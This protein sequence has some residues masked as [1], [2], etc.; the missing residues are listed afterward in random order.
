MCA[1]ASIDDDM[2][3]RLGCDG[4]RIVGLE[5]M[6]REVCSDFTAGLIR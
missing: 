6:M 3:A 4:G 2:S 5:I 1:S